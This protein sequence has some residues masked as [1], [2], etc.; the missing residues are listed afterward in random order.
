LGNASEDGEENR[1]KRKKFIIE[2]REEPEERPKIQ[3]L[4]E[5]P[6]EVESVRVREGPFGIR[7]Y[8]ALDTEGREWI[9]DRKSFEKLKKE[10]AE[11]K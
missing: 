10:G 9:I 7:E 3:T 11:I 2:I 6:R 1:R 8:T 4:L 5:G